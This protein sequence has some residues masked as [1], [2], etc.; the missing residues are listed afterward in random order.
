MWQLFLHL[1]DGYLL[2]MTVWLVFLCLVP[3]G[4]IRWRRKWA[5]EK[6]RRKL[7]YTGLSAWLC[8]GILTL[9]ELGFALLYDTTDSFD[10]TNVSRRWFEVHVEPDVRVL[11]FGNETGIQY[12]SASDIVLN[13]SGGVRHVCFLGDSFTFGHGVADVADRFS[14][15]VSRSLQRKKNKPVEVSNLA[16]PGTDLLWTEA[17]LKNSFAVDGRI[18]DAVYVL[19]LNDIEAFDDPTMSKSSSLSRFE[20]PGFLFRDTYFFNWLY[21]RTQ[22]LFQSQARSY[23]SFVKD[24]YQGDPWLRFREALARTSALCREHNCRFRVAIFP[25]LHNLGPDYPFREIHRQIKADCEQLG[26]D[27]LDLDPA[28]AAH[29][30]ER[31]T[32]NPFDAHP[33]ER[34]HEIAG[35]ALIDWLTDFSVR[36]ASPDSGDA[37]SDEASWSLERPSDD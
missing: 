22:S 31:L 27:C 7:I 26:I 21:F 37:D 30:D 20:P 17:V 2:A 33:N 4:L 13:P 18:D 5:A 6:S 24:Y 28:L 10:M 35:E 16:W 9:P 23:Y 14:D 32:V 1:S 25:F 15:R 8:F 29:S 12:R 11:E 36:T 3:V 19:C 34:A